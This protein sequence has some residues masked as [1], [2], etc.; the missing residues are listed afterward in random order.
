[1][2]AFKGLIVYISSMQKIINRILIVYML[3]MPAF[4]SFAQQNLVSNPSFE[5]YSSCP[6]TLN[7]VPL[8]NGWLNF[9]NTPDYFNACADSGGLN[10]PYSGVGFQYA[11]SG[12]GMMGVCMYEDTITSSNSPY[13][14]YIGSQL[15][16][17]LQIGVKYYLSFYANFS[18][19]TQYNAMACNKIGLKFFMNPSSGTTPCAMNNLAHLYTDSIITDTVNWIKI[20]GSFIADSSY[21]YLAIGNFFDDQN[22]DTLG[23]GSWH[24]AE[25]AAYYFID[26]ICVSSDSNFAANWTGTINEP[27]SSILNIYPNPANDFL[28]IENNLP[29]ASYS[30]SNLYGQNLV[31]GEL[32]QNV[33]QVD[34]GLLPNGIYF[35]VINRKDCY[36]IIISH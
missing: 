19:F 12:V 22:T 13:R 14:E 34:V 29:G 27:Q 11:H 9:G 1:M 7:E 18:N 23:I 10:V 4:K 17:P 25:D 35:L 21:T 20:S 26:D 33:E 3:T 31:R 5:A 30:I 6:T 15:L 36:K 8:C 24:W 2:F 28:I 32:N 16:N